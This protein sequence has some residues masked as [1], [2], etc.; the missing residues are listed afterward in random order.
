MKQGLFERWR[1]GRQI[2]K[3]NREVDPNRVHSHRG[4]VVTLLIMIIAIFVSFEVIDILRSKYR[5]DQELASGLANDAIIELSYIN[6]GFIASDQS[7]LK[8]AIRQYSDTLNHL[9]SNAYMNKEQSNLLRQLS[10]YENILEDEMNN[11]QFIKLRTA[12]KMLQAE[13]D[14]VN[15]EKSSIEEIMN[16]KESLE[17]FHDSLSAID[18]A[19]FSIIISKL[20]SYSGELITLTDKVSICVG[21]CS[22]KQFKEYLEKLEKIATSYRDELEAADA[23]LSNH[24]SPLALIES[25][26][27][28]Q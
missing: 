26:K 3:I 6:T 22:E 12:I 5:H 19:R 9:Q 23:E 14:S 17:D 18:D 15:S 20:S 28:I 13:L 2:R 4:L 27:M 16:I 8:Q 1:T 21:T 25:L 10:E 11:A 7:M 24:Y